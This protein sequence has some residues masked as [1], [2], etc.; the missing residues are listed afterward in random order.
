MAYTADKGEK[1][2]EVQT[3][4]RGGMGPPIT[5]SL[6]GKQYIAFTGG[7]GPFGNRGAAPPPPAGAAP[8]PAGA[9]PGAGANLPPDI[10]GAQAAATPPRGGAGGG[11][12][13][14]GP[15]AG[16]GGPGGPGGFPPGPP[17]V[18][19]KLL[20]FMLDGKAPLP[21]SQPEK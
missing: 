13:A 7:T 5:Y 21:N 4:M 11:G 9:A 8:A 10:A 2:L 15:A 1:L 17:P 12:A 3:G 20:V 18:T 14:A 19:P 16:V 6:D